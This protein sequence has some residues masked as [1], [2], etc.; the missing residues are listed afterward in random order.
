VESDLR[1]DLA[2]PSIFVGFNGILGITNSLGLRGADVELFSHFAD[3]SGTALFAWRPP[4]GDET[5]D[6]WRRRRS[7]SSSELSRV[8]GDIGV[9]PVQRR[10]L[11]PTQTLAR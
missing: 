5:I 11:D 4:P 2:D 10:N 9:R 3:A 7:I 1:V 8:R 6:T